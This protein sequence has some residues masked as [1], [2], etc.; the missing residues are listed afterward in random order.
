MGFAA[1][2][3]GLRLEGGGHDI[4]GRAPA[5]HMI[6]RGHFAGDVEGLVIACG[7]RADEADLFRDGGEA[8]KQRQRLEMRGVLRRAAQGQVRGLAHRQ[9]IGEKEEVELRL[10]GGLGET[11]VMLQIDAR[12]SIRARMAPGRHVMAGVV[13]KDAKR[14]LPVTA[15][16]ASFPLMSRTAPDAR[17]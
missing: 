4:P 15:R 9:P 13:E 10:F 5:A 7:R 14:H 6:E 12:V 11:D 1:E 8:A 17:T 16:H 2:V 3:I